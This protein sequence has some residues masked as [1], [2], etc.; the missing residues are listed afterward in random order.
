MP[1]ALK[2]LDKTG[3]TIQITW[4]VPYDGNS[5]MTR[6]V[7]EYKPVRDMWETSIE[8][9]LVPGNQNEA[10][11]YNLKPATTYHLRI[12]AE[13][14]IGGSEPSDTVT[15]LTSEEA[16]G[17]PPLNV[18]V[19]I[20]DQHTLKVVWQSPERAHWNGDILGYYVGYKLATTEQ[21]YLFETVEFS[22][23]EGKEHYLQITNLK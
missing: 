19:E 9:V 23:E 1:F 16:P 7:I 5:P 21:P 10:G 6:Y 8:R 18:R 3:R 22:K 20:V 11:V 17:G 14:E 12:V 4:A 13:N 15:I 2:V